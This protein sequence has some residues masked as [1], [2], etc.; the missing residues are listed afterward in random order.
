MLREKRFEKER[1]DK[2]LANERILALEQ[3]VKERYPD[4]T[5]TMLILD[6]PS[7][8]IAF[9]GDR[10]RMEANIYRDMMSSDSYYSRKYAIKVGFSGYGLTNWEQNKAFERTFSGKKLRTDILSEKFDIN[11][12]FKAVDQI[13]EYYETILRHR[14][15]HDAYQK[16]VN[17]RLDHECDK[18]NA[19]L[20]G[21]LEANYRVQKLH[22]EGIVINP[23]WMSEDREERTYYL[24]IDKNL[25]KDT[26]VKIIKLLDENS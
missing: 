26:L 5:V 4:A 10:D 7:I 24:Q 14:A 25:D 3:T 19:D 21:T 20:G 23:Q 15:Q 12:I 18:L 2:V 9:G 16:S 8:T 11:K 22:K 1:S 6:D 13:Q 17:A